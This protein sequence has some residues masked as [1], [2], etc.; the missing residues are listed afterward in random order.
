[1]YYKNRSKLSSKHLFVESQQ[2]K[3]QKMV[4]N[5]FKV[6]NEDTR[7]IS[8]VVQVSLL[9]TLNTFHIFF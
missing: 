1:M 6:N 4:W 2:Q 5:K 3:H 7:T 9:L 8:N